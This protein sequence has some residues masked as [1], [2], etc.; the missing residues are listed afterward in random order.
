MTEPANRPGPRE[1]LAIVA[2]LVV[3]AVFRLGSAMHDLDAVDR[4]FVPDDTYYTLSVARALSHGQLPS[5][6]GQDVTTGVQPLLAFLTVPAF[7]L[8]D[9][10]DVPLRWVIFL[11]ALMDLVSVLLLWALARALAGPVAGCLVAGLWATAPQVIETALNGLETSLA[12]SASLALV[13]LWR[14]AETHGTKKAWVLAGCAAG[15]ALL[16]RIDTAF[17]VAL[18]GI[19]G[20]LRRQFAATA[21][22]AGA[23]LVCVLPWWVL[24]VALRGSPIPE[25]GAAVIEIVKSCHSTVPTRDFLSHAAGA[26]FGPPF[27]HATGFTIHQ[28][29]PN[30]LLTLWFVFALMCAAGALILFRRKQTAA[31]LFCVYGLLHF[32]F[33]SLLVSA[34]WFFPRYL[35]TTQAVVFLVLVV[36]AS[37]P[38]PRLARRLA[39]G[40]LAL[41]ILCNAVRSSRF[42]GPAPVVYEVMGARG[43]REASR[44]VLSFL[45]RP[46]RVGALQSGALGYYAPPDVSVINLDGVVD[47]RAAAALKRRELASYARER[48]IT[49]LA[50]WDFNIYNVSLLSKKETLPHLELIGKG[51]PQGLGYE[52]FVVLRATFP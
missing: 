42:L 16:A 19:S 45:P 13:L 5:A 14:R 49:H 8:S 47:H 48:Q 40:V 2:I 50:D 22:A 44:A 27:F 21:T 34:F 23:A 20:L 15:V 12:L 26:I 10:P 37:W 9:D 33:Y 24:C 38:R 36:A 41:L 30:L 39:Q 11:S 32:L 46:A 6:N 7:W 18:L 35:A 1:R 3:A 31:A 29:H 4:V 52:P 17:L 28:N 25:S 51:P 43:Y